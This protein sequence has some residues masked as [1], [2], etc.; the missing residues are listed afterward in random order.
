M[1]TKKFREDLF[2]SFFVGKIFL[3]LSIGGDNNN[4]NNFILLIFD[5]YNKN[6]I[7]F[8]YNKKKFLEFYIYNFFKIWQI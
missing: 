1:K 8:I 5:F 2:F 3:V 4:N 6:M 7:L